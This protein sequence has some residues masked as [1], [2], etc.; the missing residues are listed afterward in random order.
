MWALWRSPNESEE[1][2]GHEGKKEKARKRKQ[3]AKAWPLGWARGSEN[4]RKRKTDGGGG[5][6]INARTGPRTQTPYRQ[7]AYFV[8]RQV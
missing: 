4:E 8:I 2:G 3:G 1:N 5:G 6:G 7:P